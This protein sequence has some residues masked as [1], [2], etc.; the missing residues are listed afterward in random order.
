MTCK[1][2]NHKG[3]FSF[4]KFNVSLPGLCCR[5]NVSHKPSQEVSL[6]VY[7]KPPT[8]YCQQL[9][10]TV[11]SCTNPVIQTAVFIQSTLMV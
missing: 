7:D 3:N 6:L 10:K 11:L 1:F 4:A 2:V 5:K 8:F 9:G